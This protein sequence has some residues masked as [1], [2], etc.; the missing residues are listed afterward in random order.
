MTA[1]VST[2]TMDLV[3]VVVQCLLHWVGEKRVCT[4]NFETTFS[5][6]L[7]WYRSRIDFTNQYKDTIIPTPTPRHP[8]TIQRRDMQNNS[9]SL[10]EAD[11]IRADTTEPPAPC[12]KYIQLTITIYFGNHHQL[13]PWASHI[14]PSPCPFASPSSSSYA[15][16][17]RHHHRACASCQTIHQR[18]QSGPLSQLPCAPSLVLS[19]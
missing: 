9:P 1:P 17:D 15:R 6:I 18:H 14:T 8:R 13:T 10:R 7:Y 3:K 5:L 4:G 11:V 12:R 2:L 16:R 19:C